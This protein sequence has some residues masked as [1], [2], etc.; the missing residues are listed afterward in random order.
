MVTTPGYYLKNREVLLQ[1]CKE[2]YQINKDKI[3][4]YQQEYR[5][6]NRSLIC[7]K[8]SKKRQATLKK[9]IDLKGNKCSI[10]Q[11]T[12]DSCVY[13]FHHIDPS[14]KDFTISEHMDKSWDTL[15]NE[16]NKCILVCS[17]CHRMLHKET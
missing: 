11:T 12:F 2:Y 8:R 13:D 1:K 5:A 17:N 3:K 4:L 10:C 16:V 9:L 6:K 15:Q 7:V 14:T